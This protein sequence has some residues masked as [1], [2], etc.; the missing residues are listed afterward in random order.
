MSNF[1]FQCPSVNLRDAI[2]DEAEQR[3]WVVDF[4]DCSS[5]LWVVCHDG[6]LGGDRYAS[7]G[8]GPAI[9]VGR[10]LDRILAGPPEPEWHWPAPTEADIGKPVFA[11]DITNTGFG[12]WDE[13]VAIYDGYY[14]V[15][16]KGEDRAYRSTYCVLPD[17]DN[18][19]KR[20]PRDL[21]FPRPAAAEAKGEN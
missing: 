16:D 20:P 4:D 3:G 5:D 1:Q 21:K 2:L 18:P 7:L 10:A 12:L 6:R 11:C 15:I 14:W 19:D 9:P 17:P 8:V 13:L